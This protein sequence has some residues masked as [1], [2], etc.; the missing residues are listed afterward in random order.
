MLGIKKDA[1]DDDDDDGDHSFS[2]SIVNLLVCT[3]DS[4]TGINLNIYYKSTCY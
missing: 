2:T 3:N 4:E 1:D